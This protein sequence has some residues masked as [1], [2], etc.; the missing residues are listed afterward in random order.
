[1]NMW[2]L[3]PILIFSV[4]IISVICSTISDIAK[5]RYKVK[6]SNISEKEQEQLQK[7]TGTAQA[8]SDRI[9]ALESILDAEVPDWRDD[10]E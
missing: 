3:I 7:L 6:Q 10:H 1:M 5:A 8:M 2:L 9:S 4:P